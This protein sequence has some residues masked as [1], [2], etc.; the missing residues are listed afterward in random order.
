M[1]AAAVQLREEDLEHQAQFK[2]AKRVR[3][4]VAKAKQRGL[5]ADTP[6]GVALMK[7]AVQPL[8][9]L[10]EQT[11]LDARSGK[12]GRRHI[13]IATMEKLPA[14]VLAYLT[15]RE[16]I[17]AA[18][19][20]APLTNT[21]LKLG[22]SIEEELRL[23]AFDE[24]APDLYHTI[25]RR[26]KERGAGA[27]HARKVF[28]FAANKPDT[29]VELP[30]IAKTDKLHIGI[31][32]IELLIEATGFIEPVTVRMGKTKTRTIIR[33]TETV[34]KWMED[35]NLTAELLSPHYAPM[36]VPPKDWEGVKG[37]G[38][39]S[40]DFKQL[41]LVKRCTKKQHKEVMAR[42]DLS[43]VLRA[44]NAVQ[45]TAWAINTDVLD[46]MNEV[47][48]KSYEVAMP[49]RDDLLVPPYPAGHVVAETPEEAWAN[50]HPDAKKAWM[51]GARKVYEGNASSRGKRMGIS[52][53]IHT[54]K[55]LAGEPEVFFP[56]QLDF[57]G[58]AYAVPIGLNPQGS[59]HAK[60][61]LH[62]AHGKA[63]T[64][65]RAAGWLAINGANLY[66][67]DKAAFADRIAWVEEREEQ[68]KYTAR[69]P[70]AD[71]WWTDAD[72]PW[73]FLAWIFEYA[74]FLGEGYGFVSRFVCSVDGSCNGLQHFSA[75]LRD[76]IGGAAVN[77]VPG[78]LPAD[79][80]Q[81]VADRVIEKLKEEGD[82]W[83]PRGWLDFGINRKTTKRPVMVLPYGG[84][85]KSCMEYV[86]EAVGEQINDGKENPFGDELGKATATLA[87]NVWD[88]IGDVVVAA[89]TAMDWFQ[90]CARV[91]AKAGVPLIWTTPSGFPVF[92]SYMDTTSR[93]VKTRLQGSLV[94]LSLSE[95]TDKIDAGRQALAVS[96]NAVHSLDASAM[97][98]TINLCLDNAVEQFAMVH[99]SYGTVAADMDMLAACLRHA[100]VD[101]YVEHD[102]LAEFLA[103][104]PEEVRAQCPPP[105]PKGSLD[106]R[107]VID[108]EFFFA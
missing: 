37:G 91:A 65:P 83:V 67:Y 5:G 28:V 40:P 55:T 87:R 74:K 106:I 13:A 18:I 35:R 8:A 14:E 88:S 81:R 9:K 86:R 97:V 38:Y 62:F 108:S 27:G 15:V 90:K 95:D 79:I 61:L 59:D 2:G 56:H 22:S 104:L 85:F 43:Q 57:R 29:N 63:I 75:M 72:K 52:Q 54:A 94:F 105:P 39:I 10:I 107:K 36:V 41:S 25:M 47:W 98:L 50:V 82:E 7:R 99:D 26:L 16:C 12:A 71:L 58:R 78:E 32:L 34:A 69:C 30:T 11:I 44:L 64:T 42:A 20:I 66:G 19:Q 100:F 3:D 21:G 23:Q 33:P 68:I 24:Q 70:L 80:Y 48:D 96:P 49:S 51:R 89:R 46:V 101:M 45:R 93:R 6:G 17:S 92:Q 60:A 102:V 31:R 77:L 53:I 4:Q 103:G 1:T 76:P 73:C 84:T